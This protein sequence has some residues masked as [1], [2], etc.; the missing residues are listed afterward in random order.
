MAASSSAN[1]PAGDV[2]I[3]R[4][5]PGRGRDLLILPQIDEHIAKARP[6]LRSRIRVHDTGAPLPSLDGVVAILF[7]LCDPLKEHYPDCYAEAV[8]I[9]S[10]ARK[11]DIKLLNPPENLSNSVKSRQAE[12]W[13]RA[14][15]PCA[16][17]RAIRSAADLEPAMAALGLPMILRSDD[18]HVQVDVRLCKRIKH[19]DEAKHTLALPAVALQLIDVRNRWRE[20]APDSIMARFHHKKRAMVFG[21]TVLNNHVFFS[22]SPIVGQSSCTFMADRRRWWK[23]LRGV[24]IGRARWRDTLAADYEFF[25]SPPEAPDVMLRAVAALGLHMAAIDYASLPGGE[26]VLWEANPY[27]HLPPW[28]HAVL[29]DERHIRERTGHQIEVVTGW[30][31][32]LADGRSRV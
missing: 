2:L 15:I 11:R 5:G 4:H 16:S 19:V 18:Q 3:V 32:R 9:A 8:A 25:H 10:A 7:Y 30:L 28:H 26:V 20:A 12:L 14:G 29:A 6:A 23:I 17:A 21:D 1:D 31:D 22:R 24:G 13:Q 27:V